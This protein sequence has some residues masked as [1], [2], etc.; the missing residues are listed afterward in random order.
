MGLSLTI[1][2][3]ISL[4]THLNLDR[5]SFS[6]VLVWAGLFFGQSGEGPC[7]YRSSY[8]KPVIISKAVSIYSLIV[9]ETP[10]RRD[11]ATEPL[12][13]QLF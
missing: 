10:N 7:L 1:S 5:R 2:L 13:A 9:D 3:N 8:L 6:V 12:L 11:D 4:T